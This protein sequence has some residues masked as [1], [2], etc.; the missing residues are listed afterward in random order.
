MLSSEHK[1]KPSREKNHLLLNS[2]T[3]KNIQL[4]KEKKRETRNIIN[5]K[6]SLTGTLKIR[7]PTV[8]WR[9]F[10]QKNIA[11]GEN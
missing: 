6:H 2:T 7:I 10:E 4:C 3:R 5:G 1:I 9:D 8:K 11:A